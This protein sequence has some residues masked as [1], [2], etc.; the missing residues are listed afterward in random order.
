ME[1]DYKS[2]LEALQA[3]VQPGTGADAVLIDHDAPFHGKLPLVE[4]CVAT[5]GPAFV[6]PHGAPAGR[7]ASLDGLNPPPPLPSWEVGGGARYELVPSAADPAITNAGDGAFHPFD[8][9][10]VRSTLAAVRY[11]LER[12]S[13]RE[14]A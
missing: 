9:A 8:V 4:A 12:I 5:G 1:Q 7:V 3:L 13:E 2:R 11:P 14:T 10:E 6:Y